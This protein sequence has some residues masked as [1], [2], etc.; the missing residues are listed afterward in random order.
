MTDSQTNDTQ[1]NITYNNGTY[2][3]TVDAT[4]TKTKWKTAQTEITIGGKEVAVNALKG[5]TITVNV[6]TGTV[7]IE[8]T[9]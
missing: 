9:K 3:A 4:Q 8:E 7:T 5:W 1:N 2:T 6:E